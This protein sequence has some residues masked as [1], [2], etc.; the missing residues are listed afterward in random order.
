M[1]LK[2][3]GKCIVFALL[4]AVWMG[5]IFAFSCQ[6]GEESSSMSE[7]LL[8]FLCGIFHYSPPPDIKHILTVIIRKGAHMTEFGI[9]ALLWLGTL[10][11]RVNKAAWT[12]PAAFA[13]SS[14]YAAT[15]ELHQL[16][17]SERAGQV[18][19]WMIDS[20]GAFVYLCI[21]WL[22][23]RAIENSKKSKG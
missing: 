11:S 18:T 3:N 22:M 15:D 16:F 5:V 6:N 12:F 14:L 19:D 8:M 21:V 13:G 20:S 9:L 2:R 23:I 10:R 4:T 7:K 1:F 17:V